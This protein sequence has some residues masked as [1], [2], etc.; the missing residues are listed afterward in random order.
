MREEAREYRLLYRLMCGIDGT[1]GEKIEEEAILAATD[2][3]AV[4]KANLR[5]KERS[6]QS[7][8]VPYAPMLF[9]GQLHL[10]ADSN[11]KHPPTA[12]SLTLLVR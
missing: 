8:V 5:L 4:Q 9:R 6:S 12:H 2:A 11:P 10:V 3:E 7:S 1:V